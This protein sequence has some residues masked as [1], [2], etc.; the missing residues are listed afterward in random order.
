MLAGVALL[1]WLPGGLYWL[2]AS[3]LCALVAATANAWV[4]LME[5]VRDARYRPTHGSPGLPSGP[6]VRSRR[7]PRPA[8]PG[9]P[10]FARRRGGLQRLA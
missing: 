5:V 2:A 7:A 1:G 10:H 3:V 8:P 9:L 6:R 4:L